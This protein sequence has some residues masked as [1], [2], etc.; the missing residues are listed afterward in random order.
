MSTTSPNLG[1][2]Q[3]ATLQLL[4][5]PP[6]PSTLYSTANITTFVNDARVQIAGTSESIRSTGT[7]TTT[8]GIRSYNLSSL[9]LSPSSGI[10]GAFNINQLQS[11]IGVGGNLWMRPRQYQWFFLYRL[12]AVVPNTGRPV[13]WSVQN[14]G[15][16]G[17]FVVDPIPDGAYTLSADVFCY[18]TDLAANSDPEALPYPWTDAVPY[19]AAY[20]ALLSAQRR[21]DADKMFE[22]YQLFENRARQ[23]STPP[24]MPG[25]YNQPP[26]DPTMANKFGV[27]G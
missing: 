12:S 3:T 16:T 7:I 9:T 13:E 21:D 6:A 15:I 10:G 2:Y 1:S 27:R 14:Q 17:N 8:S 18:P 23:M 4:Q 25:L 5:N 26:P 22:R 11:Q 24:V 20:L 19:F